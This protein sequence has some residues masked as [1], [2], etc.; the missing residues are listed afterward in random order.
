M[1]KFIVAGIF[2]ALA[3]GTA[4]GV[5][6]LRG[7]LAR[8]PWAKAESFDFPEAAYVR[9]DGSCVVLDRHGTRMLSVD[10]DANLQW[11]FSA[12]SIYG[13][14]I[15]ADMDSEGTLYV[16]DRQPDGGGP[17]RFERIMRVAP[18]GK[19]AGVLAQSR[20]RDKAGY[21]AGSLRAGA[22]GTLWYL[23]ASEDGLVSAV[24]MTIKD[25]DRQTVAK[26]E[27]ALSR[28]ALAVDGPDGALVVNAG[29]GL[30]RFVRGRFEALAELAGPLPYPVDIRYDKDG[31]L[32]VAD[33]AGG[34]ISRVGA[35]GTAVVLFRQKDSA[36]LT[37][38]NP[39][40]SPAPRDYLLSIAG[41]AELPARLSTGSRIEAFSLF[42]DGCASVDRMNGKVVFFDSKGVPRRVLTGAALSA[43]ATRACLAA[44]ILAGSCLL[45]ALLFLISLDIV[46]VTVV[47]R[48]LALVLAAFPGACLV[49]AVVAI[50]FMHDYSASLAAAES[51]A[52]GGWAAKLHK[53]VP[54][55]DGF[56]RQVAGLREMSAGESVRNVTLYKLGGNGLT[57]VCDSS[58]MYPPGFYQRFVP[59]AYLWAMLG[60][61]AYSGTV[62]GPSGRWSIAAAPIKTGTGTVAGVIEFIKPASRASMGSV[63]SAAFAGK[64][65]YLSLILLGLAFASIGSLLAALLRSGCGPAVP[66]Q[67]EPDVFSG[68]KTEDD[69]SLGG[70]FDRD[71]RVPEM[72][73]GNG[74]RFEP[75]FDDSGISEGAISGSGILDGDVPAPNGDGAQSDDL[76]GIPELEAAVEDMGSDEIPELPGEFEIKTL[77]D[78]GPAAPGPAKAQNPDTAVKIPPFAI[79]SVEHQKLHRQ[80]IAALKD[81]NVD[82]AAALLERI[83]LENPEDSRALNNLGVAC[84]RQGRLGAAIAYLERAL[85]LEPDNA[86]TRANLERLRKVV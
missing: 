10:R 63:L 67:R 77:P 51:A 36:A 54:S 6:F 1:K 64:V 50:S 40:A 34:V 44:W 15:S 62:E 61:K 75:D 71:S 13:Q 74:E 65:K 69:Y 45:F 5:F 27:W 41:I 28:A 7:N 82:G 56:R 32:L 46:L 24:K 20:V 35:D 33:A 66:A 8:L 47:P 84:K 49:L 55:L 60:G 68:I 73:G 25:N 30:V 59:E 11:S 70:G 26:T 85:A 17:Y 23:S 9:D 79:P 76:F 21:V 53:R 14:I 39:P 52:L 72:H 78:A 80:A 43:G 48:G 18:D 2:L 3:L 19:P 12:G 22:A 29:G 57:A 16:V 83:L 4:A 81:G 58:G 42:K 38:L 31:N 86:D 37:P